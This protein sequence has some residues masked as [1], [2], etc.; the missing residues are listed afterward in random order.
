MNKVQ[1]ALEKQDFRTKTE[2]FFV[3]GIISVLY[4]LIFV[5][6]YNVWYFFYTAIKI[7]DTYV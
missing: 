5:Y 4:W 3:P 1:I 2:L 6:L 7:W